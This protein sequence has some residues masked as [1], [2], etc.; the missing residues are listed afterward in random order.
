[1][2]VL[3]LHKPEKSD[4]KYKLNWFPDGEVQVTD[5]EVDKLQEGMKFICP[6]R[7][8]REL[9]IYTQMMEL[10]HQTI[11][12][13]E[14]IIPYL[15]GARNDRQMKDGRCATLFVVLDIIG[16]FLFPR[17]SL[18]FITVHNPIAIHEWFSDTG[19]DVKFITPYTK[20]KTNDE[21][22]VVFPDEGAERRFAYLVD[23]PYMI[24]KKS[25]DINNDHS[26]ILKYE[27]MNPNNI[28]ICKIKKVIIIDDMSDGGG[29]FRLLSQELSKIGQFEKDLYLTHNIQE[30]GLFSLAEYYDEIY[31]CDTYADVP[32]KDHENIHIF[33]TVEEMI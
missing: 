18:T 20:F 21:I 29:T 13:V 27:L 1:M 16:H 10:I 8:D 4:I 12:K 24:A 15:M 19:R 2:V 28:D 7:N 22:V 17:D 5:L 32:I 23:G 30:E 14:I 25:R 9:F 31:V 6:I 33:K 26:D 11:H 3:N